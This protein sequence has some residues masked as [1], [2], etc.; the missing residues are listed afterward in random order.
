MSARWEPSFVAVAAL[1]GEPVESIEAA[2]GDGR[3]HAAAL[4]Q[5]LRSTERV[6]RARAMA[7]VVTDVATAL[8]AAR[9]V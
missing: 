7:A 6:A 8:E 2:L 3:E 9:I 4:L 5:A 1:L